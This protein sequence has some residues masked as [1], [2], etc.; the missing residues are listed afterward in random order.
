[1]AAILEQYISIHGRWDTS[2]HGRTWKTRYTTWHEIRR[3]NL[4]EWTYSPTFFFPLLSFTSTTKGLIHFELVLYLCS[5][6]EFLCS[7]HQLP[8]CCPLAI[9]PFLTA[10]RLVLIGATVTTA[11]SYLNQLNYPGWI[12]LSQTKE[13]WH[14]LLCRLVQK[15]A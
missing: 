3:F 14:K 12:Y 13:C 15:D 9:H 10:Q 7:L 6:P 1:M 8:G 4:W 2:E 11:T 5:A